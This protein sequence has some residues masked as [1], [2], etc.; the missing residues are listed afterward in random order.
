MALS[1][2]AGAEEAAGRGGKKEGEYAQENAGKEEKKDGES[3]EKV[4]E[5]G[6]KK[7]DA[8]AHMAYED[9]ARWWGFWE[10]EEVVKL[11]EWLAMSHCINLE[12]NPV[13]KGSE[14]ATIS[15]V[16]KGLE[17]DVNKVPK[18]CG[19]RTQAPR[20]ALCI[21]HSLRTASST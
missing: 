17:G 7:L 4:T 9:T 12:T 3:A 21:H 8:G 14:D 6:Q 16:E 15:A 10:P 19:Q 2:G 13:P 5:G 18:P 20:R 11:A 1:K